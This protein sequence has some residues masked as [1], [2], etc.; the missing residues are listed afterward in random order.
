PGSPWVKP[1]R[2]RKRRD[3]ARDR[4]GAV[5]PS[6]SSSEY[7]EVPLGSLDI[8][9]AD[10]LSPRQH[11][12]SESLDT[13]RLEELPLCS[14]RMEAPKIDRLTERAKSQCMARESVNGEVLSL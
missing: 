12:G 3:R 11:V 4:P 14:C 2:R 8:T 6:V 7:T 9:P 10:S 13:D 1:S 5:G